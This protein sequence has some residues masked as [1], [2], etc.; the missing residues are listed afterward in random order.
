[1]DAKVLDF[2]WDPTSPNY[3]YVLNAAKQIVLFELNMN[4]NTCKSKGH[5]TLEKAASSL[6]I[7][8]SSAL[9]VINEDGSMTVVELAGDIYEFEARDGNLP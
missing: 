8:A 4:R 3:L 6:Q 7:W 9:A 5:I 2:T 1:M